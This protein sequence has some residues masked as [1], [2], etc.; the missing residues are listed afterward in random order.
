MLPHFL[1]GVIEQKADLDTHA[2]ILFSNILENF[3]GENQ[4]PKNLLEFFS[5]SLCGLAMLTRNLLGI[6]SWLYNI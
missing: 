2:F 1:Y 4:V 6:S 3:P 5:L